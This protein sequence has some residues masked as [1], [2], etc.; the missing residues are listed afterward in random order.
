LLD[1]GAVGF[2]KRM[3]FGNLARD[4]PFQRRG[5]RALGGA[6]H[7]GADRAQLRHDLAVHGA[8]L[9][10]CSFVDR[11]LYPDG[12]FD[13]KT[14]AMNRHGTL[15]EP[16]SER[17]LDGWRLTPGSRAEPKRNISRRAGTPT[18]NHARSPF[19]ENKRY[20]TIQRAI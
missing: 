20:S 7:L 15:P 13:T 1:L 8:D 11:H 6:C 3:R 19:I 14:L 5:G 17:V 10:S 16:N 4:R 18:I 2:Q 12:F 9:G